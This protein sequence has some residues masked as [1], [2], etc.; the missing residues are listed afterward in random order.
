MGLDSGA[1]ME[2]AFKALS[3]LNDVFLRSEWTKALISVRSLVFRKSLI[4]AENVTIVSALPRNCGS[5]ADN[6]FTSS[7]MFSDFS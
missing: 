2:Y 5:S 4:P 7:A 6:C 3:G 1:G